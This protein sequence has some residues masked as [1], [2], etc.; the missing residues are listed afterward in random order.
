MLLPMQTELR[1]VEELWNERNPT[2]RLSCL[3]LGFPGGVALL[4]DGHLVTPLP[5]FH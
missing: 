3:F 5:G 4:L 2:K 1:W